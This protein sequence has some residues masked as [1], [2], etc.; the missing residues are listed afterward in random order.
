MKGNML[1]KWGFV[2]MFGF[3]CWSL[4][5][6]YGFFSMLQVLERLVEEGSVC[7]CVLIGIVLVVV[8]MKK[9]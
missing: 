7:G 8:T 1:V 5:W 4:C 2:E 3:F 6:F 9:G